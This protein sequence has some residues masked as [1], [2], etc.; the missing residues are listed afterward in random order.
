MPARTPHRPAPTP[1]PAAFALLAFPLFVLGGD[2]TLRLTTESLAPYNM[3]SAD[4]RE[5]RGIVG[6][7]VQEMMRRAGIRYTLAPS[8]WNRAYELARTQPDT[9]AFSTA[10]L[11]EREALFKWIGPLAVTEWQIYVRRDFKTPAT[12][13]TELRGVPI[14]TYRADA[15]SVYLH[16]QGYMAQDSETQEGCLASLLAGRGDYWAAGNTSGPMLLARLNATDKVRPLFTFHHNELYLACNPA[17]GND[18]VGRLRTAMQQ[19]QDDGTMQRI[20]AAYLPNQP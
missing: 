20:D 9:C 7:K 3:I 17:V 12:G 16:A 8:G 6:D 13:I 10:R 14:N 2:P 11:P 5:V 4:L 19:M 15:I 18:L 1:W